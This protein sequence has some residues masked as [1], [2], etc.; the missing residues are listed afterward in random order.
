MTSICIAALAAALK[1]PFDSRLMVE[2]DSGMMLLGL[3]RIKVV[4]VFGTLAP[5]HKVLSRA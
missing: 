1:M 4:M 3:V 2:G 5:E